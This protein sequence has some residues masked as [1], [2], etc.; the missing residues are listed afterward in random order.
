MHALDPNNSHLRLSWSGKT[1]T[2]PVREE[3]QDALVVLRATTG[4]V[5]PLN[6][7]PPVDNPATGILFLVSDGVGGQ[8]AGEEASRLTLEVFGDSCRRA[9]RDD[10][11]R[12]NSRRAAILQSGAVQTNGSV[13][14]AA[15][16]DPK[17]KGMAATLS[18]LWII[19]N[20]AYLVQVGDSRLYRW[21]KGVIELLSCDQ[22]EIG[23]QMFQGLLTEKEARRMPGRNVLECAIGTAPDTFQAETDWF[24][25][26]PED[27][28]FLCSDGVTDGLFSSDLERIL[29]TGRRE[30][31]PL[32]EIVDAIIDQ[33][34]QNYGRDNA[35]GLLIEIVGVA[36]TSPPL[37]S[38]PL[39][40]LP[41]EKSPPARLSFLSAIAAW[42]RLPSTT[43]TASFS[44]VCLLGG[45]LLAG[46]TLFLPERN[47]R[48][49][50]EETAR[51][52]QHQSEETISS[53]SSLMKQIELERDEV[54][55][56]FLQHQEQT[57]E[58]TVGQ[59]AIIAGLQQE[60]AEIRSQEIALR[61]Q[62]IELGH[63]SASLNKRVAEKGR[64]LET[65]QG[66]LQ[67]AQEE[68]K[69]WK[70]L[71][72]ELEERVEAQ[73]ERINYLEYSTETATS[74]ADIDSP[75]EEYAGNPEEG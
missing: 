45:I 71:I 50:E 72:A 16:T 59:E 36:S 44:A 53:L 35:T 23:R 32:P 70:S 5:L 73:A 12:R 24:E 13:R 19:G 33:A 67:A 62:F 8:Q 26:C 57:A 42:A 55:V 46:F 2:G 58:M 20:R 28:Y 21:R 65:L 52:S 43:R 25:I 18:G 37:S 69:Q 10:L 48:L 31:T 41:K 22:S 74:P 17:K 30:K 29:T 3:N 51:V 7:P 40:T 47:K 63:A 6:Q 9:L 34:H 75:E 1:D 68:E 64:S 49:A 54:R 15:A 14:Q 60:L 27:F 61:T 38:D 39:V 66:A 4:E 11:D 56:S